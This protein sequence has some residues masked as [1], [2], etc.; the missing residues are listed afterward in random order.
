MPCGP[1]ALLCRTDAGAGAGADTA[2][3]LVLIV[4][5]LLVLGR[6]HRVSVVAVRSSTA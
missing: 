5:L 4:M 2:L 6:A 3:Q 1:P